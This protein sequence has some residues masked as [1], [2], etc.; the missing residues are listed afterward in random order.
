M[1]RAPPSLELL[2]QVLDVAEAV[3]CSKVQQDLALPLQS[4]LLEVLVPEGMQSGLS[5]W[6]A[7]APSWVGH[8]AWGREK[9]P[10]RELGSGGLPP[11]PQFAG[12]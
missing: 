2:H 8:G 10:F 12:L 9:A 11:Q 6:C 3:G 1:V 5:L 4:H 7:Q